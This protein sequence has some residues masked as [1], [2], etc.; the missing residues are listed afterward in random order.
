MSKS[1]VMSLKLIIMHD[2]C[3]ITY[4]L[5]L[6]AVYNLNNIVEWTVDSLWYMQFH[7]NSSILKGHEPLPGTVYYA[8]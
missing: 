5:A 2:D 1:D 6:M 7:I 8:E 4:T 3:A